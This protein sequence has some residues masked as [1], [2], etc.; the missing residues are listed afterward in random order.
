MLRGSFVSEQ[1]ASTAATFEA[2]VA[3][4][5]RRAT[6]TVAAARAAHSLAARQVPA[7]DRWALKAMDIAATARVAERQAPKATVI[8]ATPIS[9]AAATQYGL[10]SDNE[11]RLATWEVCRTVARTLAREAT[12]P[13]HIDGVSASRHIGRGHPAFR[14]PR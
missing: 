2:K 14:R 3:T 13:H 11:A 9:V 10:A 1:E 5:R 6:F 8:A 7:E 4:M 12:L